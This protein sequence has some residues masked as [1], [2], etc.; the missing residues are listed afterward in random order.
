MNDEEVMTRVVAILTKTREYV[1]D[2]A[3][4]PDDESDVLLNE[5]VKDIFPRS[6]DIDDDA[7]PQ[8]VANAI[9]QAMSGPIFTAFGAFVAAFHQL[10]E[11]HDRGDPEVPSA[12]VLRD[13]AL[14]ASSE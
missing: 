7:A 1:G 13:L 11:E 9:A 14:R 4:E 3:P 12:Q 10:A 6:V 8:E 5:L 2:D